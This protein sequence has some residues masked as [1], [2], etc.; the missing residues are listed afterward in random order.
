MDISSLIGEYFPVL[1]D[2]SLLQIKENLP[3]FRYKKNSIEEID[4][5]R[6][7]FVSLIA[8]E[9]RFDKENNYNQGHCMADFTGYQRIGKNG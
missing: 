4:V 7:L 5:L 8:A 3:L 9:K 1:S 2:R 6:E